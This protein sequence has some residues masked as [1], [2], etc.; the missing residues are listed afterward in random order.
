MRS[1]ARRLRSGAVLG[2]FNR[3][4]PIWAGMRLGDP[5]ILLQGLGTNAYTLTLG[6]LIASDPG[7]GVTRTFIGTSRPHN[8]CVQA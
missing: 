4:C 6:L 5:R 2:E 1:V 3:R 8:R 7:L